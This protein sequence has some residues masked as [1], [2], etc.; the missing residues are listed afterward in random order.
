MARNSLTPF[1]SGGLL[2]AD[3]FLS[4]HREMNRLFD[5]VMRGAPLAA[6]GGQGGSTLIAPNINVSE[7]DTEVRVTA[8]LPGVTDKDIHVDL[9]D[10]V[11]VIRGE[12]KLE[13]KEDKENFHYIER[14]Y[15]TFQRAL[16]LP[17]P[18][19]PEQVKAHFENGV[20]TV[21]LPKNARQER[22]RRIQVQTGGASQG[23]GAQI[24]PQAGGQAGH[25]SGA[26]Q[27][28]GPQPGGAAQPGGS[29]NPSS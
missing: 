22:A 18:A 26:G 17:F 2:G 6:A 21:T 15:G 12:K 14:S 29:S 10:D 20:L 11:L 27:G 28:S 24:A 16:Q 9:N 3:P 23:G 19:D 4:L 8:E 5:D 7:T 1:R 13:K 25:G